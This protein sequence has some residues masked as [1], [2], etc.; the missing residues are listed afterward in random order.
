MARNSAA[1]SPSPVLCGRCGVLYLLRQNERR[2]PQLFLSSCLSLSACGRLLAGLLA[3]EMAYFSI[4]FKMEVT[5]TAQGSKA[6][7]DQCFFIWCSVLSQICS[8]P[9]RWMSCGA[10]RPRCL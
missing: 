8:R 9:M 3:S 1:S 2:H 7:K 5:V 10:P 4:V 6:A